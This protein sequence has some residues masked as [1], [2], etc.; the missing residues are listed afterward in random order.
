[1]PKIYKKSTHLKG[2]KKSLRHQ[3]KIEKAKHPTQ[4]LRKNPKKK[5]IYKDY[6]QGLFSKRE[7]ASHQPI[8]EK[9]IKISEIQAMGIDNM[10]SS[11][12][13]PSPLDRNDLVS[14]KPVNVLSE[15]GGRG[16]F[17]TQDIPKGTCL[18]LY[19]GEVF[20]ITDF[21][22][23]LATNKEANNHYAMNVGHT[24][25]DG[26]IKGNFSRY[27]NFSDSQANVEFVEGY[28]KG[29]KV[30]K[31]M[32]TQGIQ[33]NQQFLVDYNTYDE[34]AS[35]DYFFINPDDGNQSAH[36]VYI[37]NQRFYLAPT[38][39][40][41]SYF[42]PTRLGDL[43]LK[44]KKLSHFLTYFAI[45]EI[46]LPILR[47]NDNDGISDFNEGDVYSPLMI[48]CQKGQEENVSWLIANN[49]RVNQQQ[50][51]SG[52]CPLFIAMI[53]YSYATSRK[54]R[55]YLLII[56]QLIEHKANVFVH[57]RADNTFLHLAINTLKSDDFVSTLNLLKNKLD[58]NNFKKL[59]DYVNTNDDD[60]ITSCIRN[61]EFSKLAYL[62]RAN[63]DYFKDN[64]LS[65][66]SELNQ[67]NF[68][69]LHSAI[70][71]C[72]DAEKVHLNSLL[73]SYHINTTLLNRIFYDS[74]EDL[75]FSSGL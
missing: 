18:G 34:R 8:P 11:Q 7:R 61:K 51:K 9:K 38:L 28:Y 4:S 35:R 40:N 2:V 68:T 55:D 63:P 44:D 62:L 19:T 48:A 25:V 16:L 66:N 10:T 64:Y 71:E 58:T 17:A 6:S 39:F 24:I 43:L 13:I 33:A 52:L 12:Y 57:D 20:S 67:D 73:T 74:S 1:M 72:H 15:F 59:Y 69:R 53:G 31:V 70:A 5:Q 41:D 26:R 32:T 50:N 23:L 22:K 75:A 60:V 56:H 45:E 37:E 21:Q 27:I 36:E 46:N 65:G 30:V 47:A 3:S 42:Y 49:A 54:K 29:R 14:V